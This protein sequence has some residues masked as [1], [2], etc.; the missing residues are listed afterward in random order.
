[1]PRCLFTQPYPPNLITIPSCDE[2][3]R[4][5]AENDTYLRDMLA[6][7]LFGNE[8]PV[9]KQI[10]HSKFLASQRRNSSILARAAT[11]TAKLEAFHTKQ[12]IYL[13][14]YPSFPIDGERVEKIFATLVRGLYYDALKK[15]Y[16]EGY[17]FEVFRHYPWDFK[18]ISET[19]FNLH[20]NGPRILGNV[21]G[22]GFLKAQED[23]F[24]TYWLIWFYERVLFS[25]SATNP[26][27]LAMEEAA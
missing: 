16:P 8:S 2:C 12:G 1:V 21:F 25:V 15:R 6:L 18:S 9:A 11:S 10:F 22:C 19:F 27:F 4:T 26:K 17:R 7:D 5:K 14:H 3:N 13:G 24:T 20:P 23:L